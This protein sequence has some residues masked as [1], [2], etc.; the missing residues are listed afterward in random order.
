MA[1]IVWD[2]KP[3]VWSQRLKNLAPYYEQ[4]AKQMLQK[5]LERCPEETGELKKSWTMRFSN[6]VA[7]LRTSCVYALQRHF[8]GTIHAKHGKYLCIP[9]NNK[10]KRLT[11]QGVS[12]SEII[13]Q[14]KLFKPRGKE[15]LARTVKDKL[16]VWF[17]LKEEVTQKGTKY[18]EM[19]TSQSLINFARK[20]LWNWLKTGRKV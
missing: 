18:I 11:Q 2:K 10:A 5:T 20:T 9:V 14:Y 7:E 19:P 1:R 8:G 6:K 4:V 13:E 3:T 17:A 12:V 15:V 16:E